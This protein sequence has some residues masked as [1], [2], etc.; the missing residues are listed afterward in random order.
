[1]WAVLSVLLGV[2]SWLLGRRGRGTLLASFGLQLAA[3]GGLLIAVAGAMGVGVGMRDHAGAVRLDRTTWF[4]AGLACG[5]A[6]AGAA[7]SLLGW[8]LGRRLSVVGA[9]LAVLVHGV[10]VAVLSL[11]LA[12]AIAR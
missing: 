11:M 5:L 10:A 1:M 12:G 2:A 8:L 6:L 9:G 4:A 7:V 3:W